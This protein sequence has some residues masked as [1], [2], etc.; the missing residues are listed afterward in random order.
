MKGFNCIKKLEG[1]NIE[2]ACIVNE[3]KIVLQYTDPKGEAKVMVLESKIIDVKDEN[4]NY[5]RVKL[6]VKE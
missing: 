6:D 3:E 4:T 5:Q 2:S 1:A